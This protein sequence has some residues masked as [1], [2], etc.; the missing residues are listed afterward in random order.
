MQYIRTSQLRPGMRI[1]RPIYNKRGV[2]LYERDTRLTSQ[3]IA[4][5]EKF[6]LW[7][8]YILEPAEP[9]PPLSQEDI[10]LERFLT[11]STFR[12]KD[13]LSLLMNGMPSQDILSLA[14]TVLRKFGSWEHKINF[15]KNLRSPDDYVYKHSL[16]TAILSAMMASGLRYP[17]TK[18]LSIVCAALLHDA[19][20]LLVPEEIMEKGENLLS[21]DERRVVRGYLE[22]GYQML[23]SESKD[24]GL[25]EDAL[26]IVGQLTCIEHNVK[27]PLPQN[28]NWKDGAH[29]L[30]TAGTFDNMVSVN[31]DRAPVSEMSAINFLKRHTEYYPSRYVNALTQCIHILPSGCCVEFSDGKKGIVIQENHKNYAHPVAVL[32]SDNRMIDL[33]DAKFQ[34]VLHIMDIMKSMDERIPVDQETLKKYSSDARTAETARRYAKRRLQLATA[35][36]LF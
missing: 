33:T 9:V 15:A 24:N 5:I 32:F 12:L 25:P 10:E 19:G 17:Y 6:G 30:H 29:V 3:G 22:K 28:I 14:Q 31:P 13:A 27:I 20:L 36:R 34:K 16:N 2:M 26:Q 8:L 1:A 35:G 18:Q 21:P 23:R 7:G 11:V 4:G